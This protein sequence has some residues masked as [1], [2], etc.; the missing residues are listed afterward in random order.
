MDT[1]MN[2]SWALD[3]LSLTK[4]WIAE[5]VENHQPCV[6]EVGLGC[7]MHTYSVSLMYEGACYFLRFHLVCLGWVYGQKVTSRC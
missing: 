3:R 4:C 1:S 2:I 7:W 5:L 6:R